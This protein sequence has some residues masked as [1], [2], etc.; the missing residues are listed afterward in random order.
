[1]VEK[2]K[3]PQGEHGKR[4]LELTINALKSCKNLDILNTSHHSIHTKGVW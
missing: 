4:V 2:E 1:M 3:N